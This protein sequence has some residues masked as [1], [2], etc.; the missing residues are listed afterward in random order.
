MASHEEE[1]QERDFSLSAMWGLREDSQIQAR[2]KPWPNTEF[3]QILGLS[4]L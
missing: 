3:S 4:G 2:R 1:E